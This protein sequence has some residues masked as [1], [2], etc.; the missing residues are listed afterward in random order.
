MHLPAAA[1]ISSVTF[2]LSSDH[3][4]TLLQYNVLRGS[5]INRQLLD[6][7][8]TINSSLH[9]AF[10]ATKLHIFPALAQH[11]AAL[12]PPSLQPTFLQR[13]VPYPH[14]IDIIPHPIMRDNLI[15]KLDHFDPDELWSD[16]VGGLFEGFPD[17]EVEKRG[18]VMW[19]TPW[20]WEGWELSEGFLKRWRWA[21]EGCGELLKAT[22]RWREMRGE[23]RIVVEI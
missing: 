10:A 19:E 21:L 1:S 5:L 6:H 2:P 18:V 14:W 22:N 20:T 15:G 8:D 12:I 4:I 11:E 7:I 9:S 3:L 13:S 23:E 17:D 16:T